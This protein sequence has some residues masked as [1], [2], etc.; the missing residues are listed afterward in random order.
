M[1]TPPKIILGIV[2][3]IGSGKDTVAAYLCE[4]HGAATHRFSSAMTDCLERLGLE[5]TRENTA[6]FSEI[7]RHQYGEDT[8]GRV[9]ARDCAAD[10]AGLI[11]ANGLRRAEDLAPLRA[12][13]G[14]RLVFLTMPAALRYQHIRNRGEK[15]E[16]HAMTW[17][18]FQENEQLPTEAAIRDLGAQA[19][20][21]LD[22]AGDLAHLYAQVDEMIKKLGL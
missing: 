21:T 2:G 20:F 15:A 18:K 12:L 17:E 13:T 11:V 14:F 1:N 10:A 4:R 7:V 22:N 19:D 8:F 9:I 16:E 6:A 3:E 5:K